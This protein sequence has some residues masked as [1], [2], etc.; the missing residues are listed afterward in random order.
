[1]H[2]NENGDGK[3]MMQ[4]VEQQEEEELQ[5]MWDA[6]RAGSGLFGDGSDDGF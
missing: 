6:E 5:N 2:E 3:Q 4:I 1:M